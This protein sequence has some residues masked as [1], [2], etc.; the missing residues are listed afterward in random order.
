MQATGTITISTSDAG[1]WT[2]CANT[3][4]GFSATINGN[5]FKYDGLRG[6]SDTIDTINFAS[7]G[8][9]PVTFMQF[10][11]GGGS[12]AE[13]SAAQ[14]RPRRRSIRR[15]AWWAIRPTAGCRSPARRSMG[16]PATAGQ[17]AAAV[18]TNVKPAVQSAIATAGRHVAVHADQVRRRELRLAVVADAQ[19]AIRRRLRGLSQRRRDRPARMPPP[20]RRGT[21]W[22]ARS[23]PA[24]SR[25]PR[26][27]TSTFPVSS[28]RPR[29]A[30]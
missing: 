25:P 6:A 22:P 18:A 1:N 21:R 19:D 5:T 15:S 2:F 27:R 10:E 28:I 16:A 26:T 23:R 20:R 11:N 30:T 12:N 8:T 13:F 17:F 24:T 7:A 29:P 4:D 3:D 14:G 9:Y